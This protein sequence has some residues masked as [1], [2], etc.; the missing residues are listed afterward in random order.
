MFKKGDLDLYPIYTSKIWATGTDF[1]AVKNNWVVRSKST[2][3][4]PK[5]FQGLAFN[6]RKPLFQDI[7]V[8]RALSY[9]LDRDLMN[10]KYMFNAYFMSNSYYPDLHSGGLNPNHEVIKADESRARKLL[11]RSRLEP[12]P[13]WRFTKRRTTLCHAHDA[14]LSDTRHMSSTKS[15]SSAS[16]SNSKLEQVAMSTIRKRLDNHEFDCTGKT[17]AP[18]ASATPSPC[19]TPK[20]PTT[21]PPKTWPA[22]KM[23]RSTFWI[24]TQRS[25]HDVAKRDEILRQIDTRLGEILAL[26][27]ALDLGLAPPALLE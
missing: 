20:R 18:A 11:R 1:D 7:R 27:P 17:G 8:R 25:L 13:R 23:P 5:A 15:T 19:G 24:E 4:S 21:K 3:T 16:A 14:Q 9:L 6:L 2:T 26:C 10:E 22:S 12:R